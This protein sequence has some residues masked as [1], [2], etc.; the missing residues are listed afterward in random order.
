MVD[1]AVAADAAS[2]CGGWLLFSLR[3]SHAEE[4]LQRIREPWYQ[5]ERG[6]LAR[7]RFP[8][9][10][11]PARKAE[12]PEQRLYSPSSMRLEESG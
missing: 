7:T 6:R 3:L 10:V 8:L 12:R 11:D 1:C 9:M 5:R 2:G 4:D